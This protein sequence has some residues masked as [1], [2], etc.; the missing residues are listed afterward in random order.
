MNTKINEKIFN[1]FPELESDR[2]IFSKF[3]K[4]DTEQLFKIRSDKQVMKFMDIILLNN[5]SQAKTLIKS[6]IKDFNEK[7]GITWSIVDK[8][9]KKII[10]T[11][12]FW[13]LVRQHNYAE[14]GFSLL[15]EYWGKGFMTETFKTLV[16]FGFNKMQLHRLEANVNPQNENSIKILERVGFRKEA[17]FRENYLFNNNFT[18]SAIYCLLETDIRKY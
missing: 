10:G 6:I 7:R 14:I 4:K 13:R 3:A 15:S 16:E 2:L 1:K 11:Y 9:T 5:P 8:D 18:D 12:G 17:H